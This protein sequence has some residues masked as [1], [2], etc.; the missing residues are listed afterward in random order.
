[1]NVQENSQD[2]DGYTRTRTVNGRVHSESVSR[3]ADSANYGVI[4]NGV[5]LT[6]DGNGVSIEEVRAAVESVGIERVEQ[7]TR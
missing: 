7:A 3:S 6:A 2:S 1:M 4:G 5:A